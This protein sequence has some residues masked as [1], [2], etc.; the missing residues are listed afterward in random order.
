VL[1]IIPVYIAQ[2]LSNDPVTAVGTVHDVPD[3]PGI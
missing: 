3:A 2:R 1:S